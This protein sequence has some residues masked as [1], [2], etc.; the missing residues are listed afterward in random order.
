MNPHITTIQFN[1]TTFSAD[2]SLMQLLQAKAYY[3]ELSPN[4]VYAAMFNNTFFYGGDSSDT[5]QPQ[6]PQLS[7]KLLLMLSLA[8]KQARPQ[9]FYCT[10]ENNHHNFM[11]SDVFHD[12]PMYPFMLTLGQEYERFCHAHT[13]VS[14]QYYAHIIG[15][16]LLQR[17]VERLA[18]ACQVT[19]YCAVYPGSSK[20]IPLQVNRTLFS[21]FSKQAQHCGITINEH[22]MFSP[23]HTVA[24]IILPHSG[25]T[26]CQ[27]CTIR[28]CQFRNILT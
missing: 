19:T 12:Y 27:H 1:A 21:V 5:S 7:K 10:L 20:E 4:N 13:L 23:L 3:H 11:L 6:Q 15:M 28:E 24:G 9:A 16:W 26:M 25:T 18:H 8:L 17:C 2:D 14:E 22:Y